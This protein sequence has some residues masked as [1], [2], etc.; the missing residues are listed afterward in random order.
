MKLRLNR[1]GATHEMFSEESGR[2]TI[3]GED[4]ESRS[5][6]VER[7][8]GGRF[9]VRSGDSLHPAEAVRSGERVWVRYLGHTYSFELARERRARRAAGGDLSSPMPGLVQRILVAEGDAVAER[10]PILV[11]EAMKMQLEI[12][13][14]RAGTVH[15]IL[16]REGDQIEA[17]TP[18]A[19]LEP[20][21]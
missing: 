5:I 7:L 19:E 2:I 21:S 10:Q 8:P 14:P 13:A 15:R 9:G 12:K 1:N 4:G 17:G 20:G 6:T 3:S 18:L 11:V 16:A